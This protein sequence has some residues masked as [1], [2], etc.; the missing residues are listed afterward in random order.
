MRLAFQYASV[1]SQRNESDRIEGGVVREGGGR[2]EGTR[3]R[4]RQNP[5][6][7]TE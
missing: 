7:G 5:S 1:A 6:A 2:G 3:M 4:M